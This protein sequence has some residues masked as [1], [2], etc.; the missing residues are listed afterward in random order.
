[1]CNVQVSLKYAVLFYC[2]IKTVGIVPST[3]HSESYTLS[4]LGAEAWQPRITTTLKKCYFYLWTEYFKSH[5]IKFKS[6][7]HNN[8]HRGSFCGLMQNT[9]LFFRVCWWRAFLMTPICLL[10]QHETL[11]RFGNLLEQKMEDWHIWFLYSLL[12]FGLQTLVMQ[13]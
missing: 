5:Q 2:K 3:G 9:D 8:R 13:P 12:A 6:V 10:S 7:A 4:W 1:M 11:D